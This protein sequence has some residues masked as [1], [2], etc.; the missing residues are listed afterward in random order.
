MLKTSKLTAKCLPCLQNSPNISQTLNE[1]HSKSRGFSMDTTRVK[2]LVWSTSFGC[3]TTLL[4][5]LKSQSYIS[6]FPLAWWFRISGPQHMR[7]MQGGSAQHTRVGAHTA[8]MVEGRQRGI[9]RG[10]C[11]CNGN[12]A[13]MPA[14]SQLGHVR[15]LWH[16]RL[17]SHLT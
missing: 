4:A 16:V 12:R 13:N 5:L 2:A 3:S 6:C 17:V 11:H 15:S 10:G 14:Q 7:L 9:C 8:C 1:D